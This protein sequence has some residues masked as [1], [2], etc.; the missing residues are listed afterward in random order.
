MYSTVD[1]VLA[2]SDALFGA[3]LVN[4]DSL[5]RLLAPGLDDYG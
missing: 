5:A 1:D 4:R 3:R 2:F